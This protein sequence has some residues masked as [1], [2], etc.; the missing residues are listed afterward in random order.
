MP[1]TNTNRRLRFAYDTQGRLQRL[2]YDLRVEDLQLDP[3]SWMSDDPDEMAQRG[4]QI[5]DAVN[6]LSEQEADLVYL[7]AD[8]LHA[9]RVNFWGEQDDVRNWLMALDTALVWHLG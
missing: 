8:L 6:G 7:H 2:R 5:A 1:K 3:S 9:D 4:D